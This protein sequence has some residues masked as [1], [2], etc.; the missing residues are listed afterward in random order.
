MSV[1]SYVKIVSLTAFYLLV[2]T[3]FLESYFH[4]NCFCPTGLRSQKLLNMLKCEQYI[5]LFHH[6]CA[7]IE[8]MHLK[9]IG[10]II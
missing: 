5:P 7:V 9:D 6:T 4:L 1:S 10:T 8:R 2:K 3:L